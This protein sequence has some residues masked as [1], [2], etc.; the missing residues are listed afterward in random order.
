MPIEELITAITPN[1]ASA[2]SP[3]PRSSTKKTAMIAL[4]RAKTLPAT[5]LAVER[6]EVSGGGPSFLRR[7]SASAEDRPCSGDGW[8]FPTLLFN[9]VGEGMALKL[10]IN[11][12]YWGIGP[13]GQE[14]ADLVLEA[15]R[16]GY[17]SV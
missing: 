8:P 17:E 9:R 13:A 1:S 14:A 12:G 2:Q 5:M 7:L 6:E 4:K 3:S 11:L 10:G 15:E 16:L